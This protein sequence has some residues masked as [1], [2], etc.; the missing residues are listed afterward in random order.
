MQ[1]CR[2]DTTNPSG[3][4][5]IDRWSA[6]CYG[7]PVSGKDT[8]PGHFGLLIVYVIPGFTALQG[9]PS[10]SAPLLAKDLL[11]SGTDASLAG[12]LYGTVAAI[13]A[14]LIVSA[15]RW[16]VIDTLHHRTGLRRPP[17]DFAT[18]DRNVA[19]FEFLVQNH[20]WFYQFYANM[21]VA[22]A[23]ACAT[24]GDQRAAR[25]WVYGL[26]IALFLLASRDALK[27]YYAPA[28]GLLSPRV[29]PPPAATAEYD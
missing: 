3:F 29:G 24:A 11:G 5:R 15:V 22:L 18:L 2:K 25:G 16:L 12:F 10:A 26:L 19:A 9:L 28:G 14:G 20:Y 1:A 27:R 21:V 4:L 17:L 23:W 6:R 8:V 13:T 7:P